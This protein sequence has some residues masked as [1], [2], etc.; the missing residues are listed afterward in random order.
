MA[1]APSPYPP[2]MVNENA[3]RSLPTV[4]ESWEGESDESDGWVTASD[5]GS[6]SFE[7]SFTSPASYDI[8]HGEE[9]DALIREFNPMCLHAPKTNSGSSYSATFRLV[10]MLIFDSNCR[11]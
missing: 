11:T 10:R 4:D 9:V 8:A 6:G 1:Y 2:V 3:S 5:D 7:S